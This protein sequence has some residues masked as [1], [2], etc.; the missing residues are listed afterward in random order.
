MEEK[1][2][3]TCYFYLW[4]QAREA[5]KNDSS[6]FADTKLVIALESQDK[7]PSFG[8]EEPPVTNR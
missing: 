8:P 6:F 3:A 2:K 1:E 5:H 4:E 7:Y